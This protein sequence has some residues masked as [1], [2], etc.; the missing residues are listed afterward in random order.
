[1]KPV[2]KQLISDSVEKAY[3]HVFERDIDF[4]LYDGKANCLIGVRRCGKT[5]LMHSTIRKLRSKIDSENAIYV[6]LEDD[7]L[8]PLVLS[9]LNDFVEAYYELY[10]NKR[11]EKV[12]FFIDEIQIV[13]GWEKF[14]RRLIDTENCC[15]VLSGSSAKLLSKEIH[16][17]LRGRSISTE[18]Q[19][20]SFKE[21]LRF[22][23]IDATNFGTK[24]QS[25]I[26]NALEAYLF[27]GGFPELV[28]LD[29]PESRKFLQEYKDLIVYRDLV[30][31]Y[32]IRELFPLRYLINHVFKNRATLFSINKFYN[33]IKSQGINIGK[34]TLYDY[35]A[36]L[37]DCF[38]L[39]AIPIY[40]H[41]LKEQN[42]NPQKIY[43]IDNGFGL[44]ASM[45]KDYSKS[46]ENTVY[47]HL[48]K[49]YGDELFYWKGD[50]E[51]DFFVPKDKLLINV[52]V[53][54]SNS[55]TLDREVNGLVEAMKSLKLKKATLI[56]ANRTEI[57]HINKL[58]IN[59]VSLWSWL[60]E[61]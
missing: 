44:T 55:Q 53:D 30:E 50:Q 40:N 54:I 7:R 57:L 14:I 8:F 25:F 4:K 5:S 9:H 58:E 11:N 12:Y 16:T 47:L 18:V 23:N 10:P 39:H 56:S 29:V 2:F 49:M 26:K 52:S 34:S 51:V 32:N 48:R 59:I 37:K 17:S 22:K 13:E 41:S 1:M 36:N 43:A 46:F 21:Y 33:D 31:R 28:N 15:V 38:T 60:L 61:R 42:R 45:D 24:N 20:L 6:N 19:P 3:T 35:V 27:K